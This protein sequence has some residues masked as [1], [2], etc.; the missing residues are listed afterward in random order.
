MIVGCSSCGKSN[1][2]P[3]Q[4]RRDGYYVCSVCKTVL[5]FETDDGR[6]GGNY[7][8]S[9]KCARCDAFQEPGSRFCYRCGLPIE[10][11]EAASTFVK[12][13]NSFRSLGTRANLTTVLLVI[14]A[15]IT[16]VTILLTASEIDLLQSLNEGQN[17]SEAEILSIREGLE[18]MSYIYWVSLVISSIA[19]LFWIYRASKNLSSLNWSNQE[20]SPKWAIIWWFVPIMWFF[21]PYQLM[22]E[23]WNGSDPAHVSS[24]DDPIGISTS[25]SLLKWWWTTWIVSFFLVDFNDVFEPLGQDTQNQIWGST[26][27]I[28]GL[29]SVLVSALLLISIVRKITSRQEEHHKTL[30]A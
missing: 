7:G 13:K 4:P 26:F 25:Y 19:F 9:P 10:S 28:G 2:I 8:D 14:F 3:D 29:V 15:L 18:G 1:T 17:I 21:R 12:D 20:F 22:K 6:A 30:Q 11:G 23:I 24:S 5:D 16:L 27:S